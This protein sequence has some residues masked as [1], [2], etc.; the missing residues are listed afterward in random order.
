MQ[1]LFLKSF[2]KSRVAVI[3]SLL[4]LGAATVALAVGSSLYYTAITAA[5]HARDRFRALPILTFG[6]VY[7][8]EED[9][10]AAEQL[11]RE[12]LFDDAREAF[13][14]HALLARD[15]RRIYLGY[16]EDLKALRSED[17][18]RS[19]PSGLM[20]IW[21]AGQGCYE[22]LYREIVADA[23]LI[24]KELIEPGGVY[25]IPEYLKDSGFIFPDEGKETY[26]RYLYIF[27]VNDYLARNSAFPLEKELLYVE[28]SREEL[29]P[30][31]YGLE[32]GMRC[33]L[34][35]KRAQKSKKRLS[36]GCL[37]NCPYLK[38]WRSLFTA[39]LWTRTGLSSC[40]ITAPPTAAA[41]KPLRRARVWRRRTRRTGM[42]SSAIA[43]R[44]WKPFSSSQRGI[45]SAARRSI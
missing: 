33:L 7:A 44:R 18:H 26:P 42:R 17:V 45:C 8:E 15:E 2:F 10:D 36:A 9:W 24:G 21:W 34:Y 14:A 41:P 3:L 43:G 31:P 11:R 25:V 39:S 5:N 40:P 27:E 35:G 1:G 12:R 28:I 30:L 23:T 29:E 38:R 16:A 37:R 20:Q 13:S 22:E 19:F 6:K 32:V 4:L